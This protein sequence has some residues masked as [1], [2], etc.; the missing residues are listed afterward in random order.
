MHRCMWCLRPSSANALPDPDGRIKQHQ[1]GYKMGVKGT[2]G[3]QCSGQTGHMR[4]IWGHGHL[5][6]GRGGSSLAGAL[7]L[8][9]SAAASSCIST[10]WMPCVRAPGHANEVITHCDVVTRTVMASA[11]SALWDAESPAL[12]RDHQKASATQLTCRQPSQ[13]AL[14]VSGVRRHAC[15]S[16]RN[17]R[18][19]KTRRRA[20]PLSRHR[21]H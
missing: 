7:P 2:K 8:G 21:E 4:V 18:K 14:R 11:A 19:P 20:L 10:S 3:C 17:R 12:C 15:G 13:H 16:A 6:V 9:S 1:S 5:L